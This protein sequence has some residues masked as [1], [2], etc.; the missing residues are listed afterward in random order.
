M[1][2]FF[3]ICISFL[4][5][6]SF[7]ILPNSNTHAAEIEGVE[8]VTYL[9]FLNRSPYMDQFSFEEG[10]NTFHMAVLEK[11]IEG[12][13]TYED[14]GVLFLADWTSTD[15]NTTYAFRGLSFVGL[16]IMG[17][18]E[19]TVTSGDDEDIDKVQFFGLQNDLIPD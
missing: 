11:E 15:E 10:D 3:A 7:T 17:Y 18:G 14:L 5:L 19:R 6:S 13:G 1:K 2:K 12:Q 16:V 8:G 4:A 9:T